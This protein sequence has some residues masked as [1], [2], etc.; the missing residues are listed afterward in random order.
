MCLSGRPTFDSF[1]VCTD[2]LPIELAESCVAPKF[3]LGA[4][5]I[6]R[7]IN[8]VEKEMK[9]FISFDDAS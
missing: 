8:S 2:Y 5:V 4:E 6:R 9:Y 7:C 1:M 3:I